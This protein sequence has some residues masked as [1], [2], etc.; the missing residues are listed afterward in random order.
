M[1]RSFRSL[2]SALLLVWTA[3]PGCAQQPAAIARGAAPNQPQVS[4]ID[5]RALEALLDSVIP[6]GM[7]AE[8]LPGAV[9]TLVQN[10]RVVFARG[11]GVSDVNAKRPVSPDST[12]FRIGS[13]TK[14]F[15]ATAVAQLADRGRIG[16]DRDVNEYLKR[17]QVART[18][19][20]P[21]TATHLLSHTA[22][23]DE[24]PGVRQ[25]RS[26][27]L[28]LPLHEF[29]RDK[30]VRIRPPGRVTAYSSFGM[31]LAGLLVEEVSGLSYEEYLRRHIWQPLGMQQ[32]YITPG[33][34]P[35]G[36]DYSN[37]VVTRAPYE[38]YHTV[39]ASS[40]NSTAADM[41]RF[42]IAHL[43]GGG[44]ILSEAA[45][46]QMHRRHAT[47]HPKIPGWGLGFQEND[48]NGERI[49]EHGG[50][51]AGFSALL[52]LLPDRRTGFFVAHHREGSNLR[53]TVQQAVLDRFYPDRHPPEKLPSPGGQWALAE[54]F[55]GTFRW[56]IYCRT[57][58]P[59]VQQLPEFAVTA[60]ED[61]SINVNRKR[62]IEVSPFYF[63]STEGRQRLGFA[64][65][66]TGRVMHLTGGSWMVMERVR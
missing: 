39:P 17:L 46:R 31:A 48:L 61:G 1:R 58:N 45:T 38:W 16:L 65:D 20:E 34:A 4:A 6:R 51:I 7:A 23:F 28:L 32:T 60:N 29:L 24:L 18:Y 2:S 9:F 56:N 12:V 50:D 33:G 62:W 14:V 35:L 57:C 13:I 64:A 8:H 49:F 10:G 5:P 26:A 22:G 44:T 3:A 25:A 52:V 66:S 53:F 19:A 21:V 30:L 43:E 36:Y 63:R 42:M 54:R 27:E 15:T 47:M 41:A 59:S 37:D 11:Y 40:I 55:V